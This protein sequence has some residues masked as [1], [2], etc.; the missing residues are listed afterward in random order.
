MA[1]LKG[2]SFRATTAF[3][4]NRAGDEGLH[5]ALE[6]LPE[7]SRASLSR[8]ILATEFYPFEWIVDLMDAGTKVIGGD[9]R[10]ILREI[11]EYSCE[12][13]LTTVYKIFF[14]V[15][16]PDFIM[17]KSSQVFSTYFRGVGNMGLVEQSKGFARVHIDGFQGGHADF[18]RRLDGYFA[19]VLE[20]S[21]GRE[22]QVVH[23]MCAYS[24]GSVCEW[25]ARW[26]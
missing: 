2:V 1:E 18:C 25:I 12:S 13:A 8:P 10:E 21:G 4:K 20:L 22:V 16:S 7:E 17:R 9:R 15:G 24:G 6:L 23:S 19:K 11:G 3:I 14:K 5:K 26:Q